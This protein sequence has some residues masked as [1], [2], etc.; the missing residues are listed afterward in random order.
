MDRHRLFY[1]HR[2]RIPVL[3]TLEQMFFGLSRKSIRPP[4]HWG[5]RGAV[6]FFMSCRVTLKDLFEIWTITQY[7]RDSDKGQTSGGLRAKKW[8]WTAESDRIGGKL[9]YIINKRFLMYNVR[10]CNSSYGILPS[11]DN[12][13]VGWILDLVRITRVM[14]RSGRN[15]RQWKGKV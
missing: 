2:L 8:V 5:I 11:V 4:L 9:H 10:T 13:T 6:E 7:V 15:K 1:L 14:D 12:L 3:T